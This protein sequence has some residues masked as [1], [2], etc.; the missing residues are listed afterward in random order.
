MTQLSLFDSVV[1]PIPVSTSAVAQP[2]S[3]VRPSISFPALLPE[4]DQAAEEMATVETPVIEVRRSSLKDLAQKIHEGRMASRIT[5]ESGVQRMGD[6]AKIV[7]ERYD[8]VAARRAAR[9]ET[10]ANR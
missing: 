9:Q 7:M 2:A 1:A 3:P 5:P 6:L 8:M 10:T 4:T